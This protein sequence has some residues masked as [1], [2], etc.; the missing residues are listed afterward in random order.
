MIGSDLRA[1]TRLARSLHSVESHKKVRSKNSESVRPPR[2]AGER[3][4]VSVESSDD[5]LKC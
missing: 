4:V 3:E 5:L 1:L 2:R